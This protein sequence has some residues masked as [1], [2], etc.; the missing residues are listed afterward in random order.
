M[1]SFVLSSLKRSLI[2]VKKF[3]A[4]IVVL[5]AVMIS[6]SASAETTFNW[7]LV[8]DAVGTIPINPKYNLTPEQYYNKKYLEGIGRGMS[9]RRA[10][11]VAELLA[12]D[13]QAEWEAERLRN[14]TSAT[15]YSIFIDLNSI[16][17]EQNGEGGVAFRVLI[18][19]TYTA[20]GREAYIAE[21]RQKGS[22][23]PAGIEKL[24]TIIAKVHFKSPNGMIK[25]CAVTDLTAYT[26]DGNPIQAVN[27]SNA[28]LNWAFINSNDDLDA[29]FNAAYKYL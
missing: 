10:R 3:I 23:V 1:W 27:F 8:K 7:K 24:S 16:V 18:A 12:I 5:C 6:S 20:F 25:Y 15:L 17:A 2:A 28:P 4:L 11:K 22:T 9:P 13:Y 29:V 14:T 21:L 19:Q 26:T